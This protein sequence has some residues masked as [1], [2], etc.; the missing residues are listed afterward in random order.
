MKATIFVKPHGTKQVIEIIDIN[1]DD[2]D[3][4]MQ[5]NVK[6]S[7]EEDF[8]PGTFIAY[9]DYGAE[10][11]DGEPDEVIVFSAGRDC[12]ETMAELRQ[13]VQVEIENEL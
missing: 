12:R 6:V 4:F 11:E 7:L 13:L 8:Q 5:H 2:E 3:Y 1:P 9:A 10:D